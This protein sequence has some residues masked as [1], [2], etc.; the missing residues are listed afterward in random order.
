MPNA[1]EKKL[2]NDKFT[3][4][5]NFGDDIDQWDV[6]QDKIRIATGAADERV[7]KLE[8]EKDE[9]EKRVEKMLSERKKV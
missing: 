9:L 5:T 7:K 6:L 4:C 2:L 8:A 1:E 3:G